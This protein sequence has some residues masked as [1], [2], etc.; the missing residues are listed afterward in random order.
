M[1]MR[2]VLITGVGKGIGKAL[3]EKFL[4]EKYFVIG[5]VLSSAVSFLSKNTAIY[6][7]DLSSGDSIAECS[8]AISE[9]GKRID[10]L[11]NN[12]GVL[13]D[14]DET[15]IVVEKL[16]KTLEVN[17]I[18]ATDFTERVISLINKNGHIINISSTAG[19]V[20]MANQPSLSHFPYHYPSYKIS[21]AALNM[22]TRTLSVRLQEAGITVSSV[23]PGWVKTDIGGPDAD[24]SPEESADGIYQIAIARPETGQFWFKEKRLPW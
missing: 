17:L 15:K 22:Y 12:A 13:L 8:R 18:G 19:S 20:E 11:I 24:L 21:K 7:L 23:H 9:S 14:E 5:T 10:I 3:A 1:G 4:L 6:K 2:T 16:R